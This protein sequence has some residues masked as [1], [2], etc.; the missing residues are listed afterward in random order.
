MKKIKTGH[1]GGLP[2]DKGFFRFW[3]MNRTSP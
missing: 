1:L 2:S 3:S